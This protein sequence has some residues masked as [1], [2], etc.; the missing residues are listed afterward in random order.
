MSRALLQAHQRH[1]F[2]LAWAVILSLLVVLGAAWLFRAAAN[3]RTHTLPVGNIAL[4]V[5]YS[6]Y[7]INEPITFTVKNNYNSPIYLSNECPKEPLN[8]YRLVG[9]VWVR[10]HDTA[11]VKDCPNEDRQI[12]VPA[13]SSVNGNFA[14]WHNL[15]NQPGR[16]RV[17]AYV[18]YYSALPYQEFDV[19]APAALFQAAIA[20]A[21]LTPA[22]A[23]AVAAAAIGGVATR[24]TL[25]GQ[26]S[27]PGTS[28]GG[29]VPPQSSSYV[30]Q[31]YTVTVNSSGNYTP[32]RINLHVSD[33]LT[34]VY[35]GTIND[36]VVTTFSPVAPTTATINAVTVDHDNTSRKIT[37]TSRGTWIFQAPNYNGNSG[38]LTVN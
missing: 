34:I 5:P 2:R 3:I 10:L 27:Y 38:T 33:T 6:K 18:E 19:I 32:T 13:N 23:A 26:A 20:P 15:F 37:L 35:G 21:A 1:R 7:L 29:N 30:P 25:R 28:T 14:S 12:L 4:N 22:A 17:V 24:P 9:G 36:E 31:N 16:Y 11:A 8:V